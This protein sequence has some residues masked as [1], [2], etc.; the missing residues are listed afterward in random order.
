M[1]WDTELDLS[2]LVA[3]GMQYEVY[4]EEVDSNLI[5]T[6]GL[7]WIDNHL[8]NTRVPLSHRLKEK[9][10]HQKADL[11]VRD[12]RELIVWFDRPR[13]G[14]DKDVWRIHS[15]LRPKW[16]QARDR[17]RE[18]A[19]TASALREE[20]STIKASL[21]TSEYDSNLLACPNWF[22][23]LRPVSVAAYNELK[24]AAKIVEMGGDA[25]RFAN[26]LY[27]DVQR[28]NSA[29]EAVNQELT[30]N[31]VKALQDPK[32]YLESL[33][34][35][36]HFAKQDFFDKYPATEAALLTVIRQSKA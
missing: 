2:P 13:S 9:F 26:R 3:I 23:F 17:L 10:R 5:L 29:V 11:R 30:K 33:W 15:K 12:S 21:Q 6:L 32:K 4:D 31:R 25:S 7:L 34:L 1:S 19:S 22:N 20:L 28:I 14:P 35:P 36:T 8:N 24:G 27:E 18:N 16:L